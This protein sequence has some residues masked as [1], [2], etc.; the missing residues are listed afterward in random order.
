MSTPQ[1]SA[2]Q[3]SHRSPL[4]SALQVTLPLLVVG[5]WCVRDLSYQWSALVDYRFGWLVWML[6]AFLAWERWPTRPQDDSPTS[7]RVPLLLAV[8]GL[9]LLTVSEL[10]RIGVARTNMTSFLSSVSC[11]LFAMAFILVG[12][13]RRTLRHF[14]F[15]LLFLFLSVPLPKML[16]NPIVLSLQSM[17]AVLN[18]EILGVLGVPAERQG[19]VIRLGTQLVGVDEACSGIRSLQSSV[20]VALF[21][22]DLILRRTALKLFF[23]GA[24]IVLAIIGNVFRSLYLSWVANQGGVDRLTM[25]HD[26]A[27]WSVLVFTFVGLCLLAKFTSVLE[28]V[29]DSDRHLAAAAPTA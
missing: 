8:P 23:L 11:C 13:G 9:M 6:G 28:R 10:Y 27:G 19:N 7:L 29:L 5:A 15:P 26:T 3:D 2:N 21:L 16:W 20:M 25:L 24:G 4:M 17:I 12:R 22:G 14:L 1:S 18:V